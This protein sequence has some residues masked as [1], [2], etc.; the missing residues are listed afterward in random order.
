MSHSKGPRQQLSDINVH[1]PSS[2]RDKDRDRDRGSVREKEVGLNF[3]LLLCFP[4]CPLSA[5]PVPPHTALLTVPLAS[6]TLSVREHAALRRTNYENSARFAM[7]CAC[8]V[9]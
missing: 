7:L 3:R 5:V 8:L 2:Q 4:M 1:H 6:P 9:A